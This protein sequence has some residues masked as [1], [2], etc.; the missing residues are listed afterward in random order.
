MDGYAP[1]F[2]AVLVMVLLL[3]L[4]RVWAWCLVDLRDDSAIDQSTRAQ[5]LMML[6][7][8][9]VVAIPAYVTVGPGRERWDARMLW[10]PWR[11]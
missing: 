5:W 9:S 7:L 1:L 4:V 6:I 3:P 2:A 8:L 11:R 10:W